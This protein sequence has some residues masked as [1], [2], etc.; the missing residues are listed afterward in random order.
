[1]PRPG[2]G[3]VVVEERAR[4][5]PA[6]RRDA[7]HGRSRG[8]DAPVL[9]INAAMFAVELVA[10]WLAQSSGLVADSLDMLADAAVY[11][12]SLYAVGRAAALKLRAAHLAGWLQAALALGALADV[13]RRLAL[14][15]APEAPAMMAVSL[16]ALA[17]NV[18]SLVLVVAT[19]TVAR[20]S[21]RAS[22][23]RRTTCSRTSA[24]SSRAPSSPLPAPACPTS[25]SGRRSRRWCSW[26]GV[27]ILRLR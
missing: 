12:L 17:A 27:R 14:G 5:A 1:M 15:S 21:R 20:T 25:R 4:A 10:G 6:P 3:A 24:S 8:A 23:S 18:A 19:A 16:L 2:L 26:A 7:R 13:V 22:S 11:A 9:A